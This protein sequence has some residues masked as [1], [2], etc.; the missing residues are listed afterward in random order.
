M[1]HIVAMSVVTVRHFQES[2]TYFQIFF[3]NMRFEMLYCNNFFISYWTYL[4]EVLKIDNECHLIEVLKT[5]NE[6][7]P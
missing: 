3:E 7:R 5:D 1:K 2:V 6:C 4:I